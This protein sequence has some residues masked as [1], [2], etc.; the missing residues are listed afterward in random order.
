MMREKWLLVTL[1]LAMASRAAGQAEPAPEDYVPPSRPLESQRDPLPPSASLP[2]WHL[3]VDGRIAVLLGSDAA[4]VARVGYGAG[5][6]VSRALLFWGPL[7]FGVGAAF[8]YQR[9]TQDLDQNLFAPP[10]QRSLSHVT[11]V[12]R[13]VLDALLWRVRP[14][15]AFGAG[16]SV[17][18]F[19]EPPLKS[20]LVGVDV[21][22]VLPLLQVAT[23]LDFEL[24]RG[25]ELG[26]HGEF[27]FTFSSQQ[28]GPRQV[29]PFAP[30]L[31]AGG[32]DVGFRF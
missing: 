5:V 23:G 27:D 6:E 1:V 28:V 12:A 19:E 26:L 20:A 17:S 13:G 30:G 3:S 31:F 7:R 24:Y 14:F 2:V 8:G 22:S 32:L 21:V 9:F 16:L 4:G 25:I 10:F 15:L 29:D 11:F 18:S